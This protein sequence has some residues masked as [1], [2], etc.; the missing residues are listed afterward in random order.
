MEVVVVLDVVDHDLLLVDYSNCSL[1]AMEVLEVVGGC[2][3]AV[4]EA[5]F[6]SVL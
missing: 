6:V 2:G 1:V 5:S 4:A 3:G